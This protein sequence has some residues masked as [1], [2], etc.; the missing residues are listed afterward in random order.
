[1]SVVEFKKPEPLIW[2][3]GDCG[4][5]TWYLL[6]NGDIQCS[7]C[8]KLST[9]EPEH[10]MRMPE[11]PEEPETATVHENTS[12]TVDLQLEH[13]KRNFRPQDDDFGIILKGNGFVHTFSPSGDMTKEQKKWAKEQLKTAAQIICKEVPK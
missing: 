12:S 9:Y 6:S 1:M 3:C 2:T 4:G 5:S 13:F 8:H 7:C 10:W 11:T